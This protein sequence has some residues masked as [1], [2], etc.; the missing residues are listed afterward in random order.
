MG[1]KQYKSK[2]NDMNIKQK[3]KKLEKDIEIVNSI[4]AEYAEIRFNNKNTCK[5]I[6][7]FGIPVKDVKRF[8]IDCYNRQIGE[9]LK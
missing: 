6:V 9:L 7:T 2:E 3:V 8:I 4:D 5:K 1:F